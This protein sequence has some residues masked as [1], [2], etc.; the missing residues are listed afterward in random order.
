MGLIRTIP[1]LLPFDISRIGTE[2]VLYGI[3]S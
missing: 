2:C 1:F 3:S